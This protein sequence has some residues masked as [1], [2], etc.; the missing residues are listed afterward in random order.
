MTVR[1]LS[2]A[3]FARSPMDQ[4]KPARAIK[5][6]VLFMPVTIDENSGLTQEAVTVILCDS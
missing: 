5:A 6:C 1:E 3:A 2:P 4:R